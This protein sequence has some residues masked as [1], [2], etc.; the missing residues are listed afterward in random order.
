MKKRNQ[1]GGRR[2]SLPK[3]SENSGAG[4]WIYGWHTVRAAL[5]NPRRHIGQL[6]ATAEAATRLKPDFP[7]KAAEIVDRGQIEALLP[8]G[9]VHQGI[10]LHAQPLAEMSLDDFLADAPADSLLVVLDQVTD[11]HNVGAIL[12]S[13]AAFGAAALVAHDR[14]TPPATGVLAKAASGALDI[15]PLLRVP[16]LARALEALGREGFWRI[17]FDSE[18]E[19]LLAD[20][21][22]DGRIA[23]VLGAEG[24][25]LRRLTREACDRLV[26]IPTAGPLASLNVSNAAAVALYE[27]ARH[28]TSQGSPA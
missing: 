15:V 13:A 23:L 17:G 5:S 25:G 9:A 6:L 3:R 2:P 1:S 16:N 8:P 19:G 14:S 28:R 21:P 10:A 7:G 27:A 4:T 26:R 18:A 22:L 24:S 11:P 20:A 12:R